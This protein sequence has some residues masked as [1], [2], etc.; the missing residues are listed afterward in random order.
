MCILFVL[1]V[2][3]TLQGEMK[4]KMNKKEARTIGPKTLQDRA[5]IVAIFCLVRNNFIDM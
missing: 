3:R 5:S 2:K 4:I 1:F